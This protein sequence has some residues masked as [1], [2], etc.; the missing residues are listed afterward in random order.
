MTASQYTMRKQVGGGP[1][2]DSVKGCARYSTFK[3]EHQAPIY[4]LYETNCSLRWLLTCS[5]KIDEDLTQHNQPTK[6]SHATIDGRKL[7]LQ[8][9]PLLRRKTMWT[10][11][12]L[13]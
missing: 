7:V 9:A 5:W 11:R 10:A 2:F 13:T 1:N 8:N 12:D 6:R 3:P 4:L